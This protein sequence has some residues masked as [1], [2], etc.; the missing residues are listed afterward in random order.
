MF[1]CKKKEIIDDVIDN[2]QNEM[3]SEINY[4][5]KKIR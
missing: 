3:I 4:E 1:S 5:Q 2:Q